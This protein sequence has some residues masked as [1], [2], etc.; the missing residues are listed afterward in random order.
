MELTLSTHLLVYHELRSPALVAL[1]ACGYPKLELWLAEPHV[2]WRQAEPLDRFCRRLEDHGLAVSSV[3]L[4]FYPSVPELLEQNARWSLIA[5]TAEARQEALHAAADGLHAAGQC[6]ATEAV[7]HL[8]WQQD[9]WPPEAEDWAREAVLT[10][11]PVAR[12]A[13]V[14]LLLENIISEGTRVARLL[15]LLDDID[16]AGEVGLCVDLGH[17]HVEGDVVAELRQ[18]LPRLAHLHLHDNDGKHDAH[19]VPGKGTIPWAEVLAVLTEAGYA[20]KAALELRDYG[21][22]EVAEAEVLRHHLQEVHEFRRRWLPT[23]T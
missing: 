15:A 7:L 21:R 11:I 17:A 6:G 13:K 5:A 23:P 10:L 8:G 9:T 14:R 3:H 18:A 19:L 22:G 16:P 20:G 12:E 2:P 4:P 1:G